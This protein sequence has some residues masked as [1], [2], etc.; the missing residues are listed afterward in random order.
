MLQLLRKSYE[1]HGSG[2]YKI[3]RNCGSCK[4]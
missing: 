4:R 3:F 1:V 2:K